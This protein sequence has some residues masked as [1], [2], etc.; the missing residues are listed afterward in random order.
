MKKS[1]KLVLFIGILF[2][3]TFFIPDSPYSPSVHSE[4]SLSAPDRPTQ[5][6]ESSVQTYAVTY[7]ERLL[8]NELIQSRGLTRDRGDKIISECTVTELE[9]RSSSEFAVN[10]SCHGEIRDIYRIIQPTDFSY[11]VMYLITPEST[12]EL[13]IRGYPLEGSRYLREPY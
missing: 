3:A 4:A 10:M 1:H 2:L 9:R 7:E 5:L 12:E 8:H 6:T 13:S 11:E